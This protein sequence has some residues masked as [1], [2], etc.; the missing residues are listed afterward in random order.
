MIDEKLQAQLRAKYNPDGSLLR[1][2]QLRM[3]EILKCVDNICRKHNIPYWLSSGTL[4]GAVRHGGF[5]PWDDDLD[6]EMLRKDY[7]KILP[8]LREELPSKYI[9]Q[10][11]NTEKYY[12]HLFVKVRDTQSELI[13]A[14]KFS[15][16]HKGVF[17]DIF[18]L[19]KSFY[20]L[21]FLASKLYNNLCFRFS[22]KK[23]LFKFNLCILRRIVFPLFRFISKFNYTTTLRHTFG[24]NYL[25]E[26]KTDEIFPLIEIPFEDSKF[27]APNNYDGY[28]S[29]MFGDYMKIPDNKICHGNIK[30]I[31]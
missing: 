21:Y 29:R 1:M 5:I 23:R 18:S 7:V 20:P 24:M 4:L 2:G 16:K 14:S 25:K 27:F 30:W 12:P 9:L 28:L 3:L 19:E 26:R 17:I 22:H 13:E 31:K 11:D 15:F 8:I 10:D 6:I